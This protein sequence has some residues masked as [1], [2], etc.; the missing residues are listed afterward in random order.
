ML[1]LTLGMVVALLVL[2]AIFTPGSDPGNNPVPDSRLTGKHGARAAYTLLQRSGYS[3]ERWEQPLSDL[4]ERADE[5]TVVILAD[6]F[7]ED[8]QDRRSVL[9]ILQRG[10]RVI[11]TGFYGGLLLPGNSVTSTKGFSI[12]DCEAQPEGFGPLAGPSTIWIAPEAGWRLNRAEFRS[13][14]TCA[15]AP[16]VVEYAFGKGEAIW[17]AGS[18]PL[19]NASIARSGNL[20]LL[21][22]SVGPREGHHIYWDESLHGLVRTPWDYT[23]GP[24]W[25]LLLFGAMGLALL[26]VLSFSRRS[27]PLRAMPE[28]PRTTPIEFVEALGAL[29]RSAGASTTAVEIAWERFRTQAAR[30]SGLR[31]HHLNARELA[32]AMERRFGSVAE[33]M[34][35]DLIA[36]EEACGNDSLK[37]RKALEIVQTLRKHEETLRVASG[38]RSGVAKAAS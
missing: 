8:W 28:A 20:D 5:S 19:E 1:S 32:E 7:S 27:G 31:S 36:A 16:V 3:V 22:H 34:E 23:K 38:S 26:V 2:L 4:A 9:L 30:L 18:T 25:P 24:L 13:D 12:A 35:S 6:P 11:A 15:S 37:P 10:G 21:L 29:Y 33:G 14:Y 17:W